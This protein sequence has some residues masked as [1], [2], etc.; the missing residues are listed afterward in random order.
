MKP[1]LILLSKNCH[2]VHNCTW[3]KDSSL[4]LLN[5][6][7]AESEIAPRSELLNRM[8]NWVQIDKVLSAIYSTDDYRQ[9]A[10]KHMQT[11]NQRRHR[12]TYTK[13]D[14]VT[15]HPILFHPTTSH[16]TGSVKSIQLRHTHTHTHTTDDSECSANQCTWLVGRRCIFVYITTHTHACM[17]SLIDFT[18]IDASAAAGVDRQI[19]RQ[20]D[21]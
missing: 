3:M 10:L 19:D 20:T 8:L 14:P 17:Y 5:I 11:K 6:L 4:L 2:S 9:R 16:D 18:Q 15:S 1:L 13:T 21:L 12:N 7:L